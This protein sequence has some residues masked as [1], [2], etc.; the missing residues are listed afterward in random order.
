MERDQRLLLVQISETLN[1]ILELQKKSIKDSADSRDVSKEKE[2][3]NDQLLLFISR[4]Y[5]MD[6]IDDDFKEKVSTE[7]FNITYDLNIIRKALLSISEDI[8]LNMSYCDILAI[9]LEENGLASRD[10]IDS[11]VVDLNDKRTKK[12]KKV[13]HKVSKQLKVVAEEQKM[14]M[15]ILENSPLKG[16]A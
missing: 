2:L 6:M 5:N 10:E 16:E 9:V 15:D 4:R 8:Q 1:E 3:L 11:M 13:M 14:L 12:T 7:L